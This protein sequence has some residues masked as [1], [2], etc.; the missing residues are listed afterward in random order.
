[1]TFVVAG[2]QKTTL[3]QYH[4]HVN[5]FVRRDTELLHASLLDTHGRAIFRLHSD[6]F[7]AIHRPTL[8]VVHKPARNS[9]EQDAIWMGKFS[10]VFVRIG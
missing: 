1:M 5:I 6:G 10:S 7:V 2:Y 4:N 8:Q 9:P 3:S